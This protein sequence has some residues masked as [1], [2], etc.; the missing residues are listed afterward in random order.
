ML[1]T[2]AEV[3]RNKGV[4]AR[5]IEPSA[6]VLDSARLMNEHRIGSLIV[7]EGPC[8]VG[9]ITERDLLT[10]VIAR[11]LP[12]ALTPVGD[13]MTT[14]VLTCTPTTSLDELRWLM[15][16]RRIRHVPVVEDNRL[17]GV[18][19]IGDLNM[20]ETQTL[21]E[22]VKYLESYICSG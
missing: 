17:I 19:S 1:I 8:V 3:L 18:I 13:V 2:V 6:S 12:P 22:T 9:I 21:S 14:P 4:G 7:T 15:R 11:E 5:T 10:R 16:S 20:A